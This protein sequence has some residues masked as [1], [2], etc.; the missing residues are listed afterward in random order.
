MRRALLRARGIY[1]PEY[2][3]AAKARYDRRVSRKLAAPET[4]SGSHFSKSNEY[5]RATVGEIF[6]NLRR[7]EYDAARTVHA[8]RRG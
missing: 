3:A 4:T 8:D 5:Y 7:P 1:W 6:A 2:A